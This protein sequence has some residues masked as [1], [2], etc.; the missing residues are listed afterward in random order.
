[1]KEIA[2]IFIAGGLGSVLRFGFGK[3][4]SYNTINFPMSTL[5]VNII[6]SFII[7]LILAYA[8]K[9]ENFN[10]NYKVILATGFCGGFTTF[11]ALSNETFLMLKQNN[12]SSALLYILLTI[13][14]GILATFIGYKIV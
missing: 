5:A 4:F 3:L 8:L 2:F 14:L 10:A 12:I 7:G 1:M 13:I 9:N 11:S 6:G